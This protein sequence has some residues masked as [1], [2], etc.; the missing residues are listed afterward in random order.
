MRFKIIVLAAA[1]GLFTT[2]AVAQSEISSDTAKCEMGC[3]N[4]SKAVPQNDTAKL[5]DEILKSFDAI[6]AEKTVEG[7]KEKLAAHG[8][9]LQEL[10]AKIQPAACACDQKK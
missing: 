2:T 9:L 7:M 1:V 10:Q 8:F 6:Q 5:L 3:C 4:M